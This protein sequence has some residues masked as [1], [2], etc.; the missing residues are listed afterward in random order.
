MGAGEIYVC[1]DPC[2][3]FDRLRTLLRYTSL[4]FDTFGQ[5][6]PQDVGVITG[7]SANK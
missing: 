5:E 4:P 2:T 3:L 6:T 1:Y 7:K